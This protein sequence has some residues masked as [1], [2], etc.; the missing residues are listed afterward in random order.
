MK[1]VKLVVKQEE[2]NAVPTEVMASAI[3]DISRGVKKLLHG[4]LNREA[5]VAL[6]K[7]KSRIDKRVIELVLNNLEQLEETWTRKKSK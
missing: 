4:R 1:K 5:V 3:I 6:I 2:E 7:D